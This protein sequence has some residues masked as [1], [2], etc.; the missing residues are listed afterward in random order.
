MSNNPLWDYS[1]ATYRLDEV[2]QLCIGLQDNFGVDVNLLMYAG[3]LAHMERCLS[4]AHLTDLDALIFDW[5]ENVVK[6]L[7]LLRRQ[8]HGRAAAESIRNEIKALELRAEQQQ[9]DMMYAFYQRA[10]PLQRESESLPENLALVARFSS[11]EYGGWAG[12][13]GRLGTILSQ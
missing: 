6:P 10:A 2:A 13:L 12:P 8:L 3:W 4:N 5:R 7:R 1:V 11:L 9:Q